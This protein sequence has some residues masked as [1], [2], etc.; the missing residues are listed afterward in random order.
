MSNNSNKTRVKCDELITE[1]NN[2]TKKENMHIL[3]AVN[4]FINIELNNKYCVEHSYNN[5]YD[6]KIHEFKIVYDYKE[7]RTFD[8][9]LPGV[10]GLYYSIDICK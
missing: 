4:D 9:W 10:P 8:A 7:K 1:F 2:S 5:R 6:L 3:Y